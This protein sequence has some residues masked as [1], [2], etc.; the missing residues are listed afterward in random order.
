MLILSPGTGP[1]DFNI[2]FAKLLIESNFDRMPA[3]FEDGLLSLFSTLEVL[4]IRITL[5]KPPG[6][7][8]RAWAR[9]H[10]LTVDPENF[11]KIG[12]LFYNLQKGAEADPAFRNA[13]GKSKAQIEADVDRYL[14]AGNFPTATPSPRPMSVERDFPEQPMTPEDMKQKL[15]TVIRDRE[16]QAEYKA[17][18]VKGDAAS[19]ARAIGNFPEASRTPLPV[20]SPRNRSTQAD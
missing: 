19:L 11:G 10:M 6:Q 18:V 9:M 16:L 13:F 20:G 17:L 1:T 2:R 8:D 3:E 5:G 7:R 12:V 14:A 4:G 15:A